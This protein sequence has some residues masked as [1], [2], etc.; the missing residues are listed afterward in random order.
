MRGLEQEI[1]RLEILLHHPKLLHID[2]RK[3]QISQETQKIHMLINQQ[4]NTIELD[5]EELEK[6]KPVF[7]R[8]T[9]E[10]K[11]VDHRWAHLG[12]F[13]NHFK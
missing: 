7:E 4:T 6:L 13:S 2:Q 3:S 9:S 5:S 11:D 8:V 10:K 1:A 12:M